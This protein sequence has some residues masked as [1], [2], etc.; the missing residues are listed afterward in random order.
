[1]L[2]PPDGRTLHIEAKA[3]GELPSIEQGQRILEI[4][5]SGGLAMWTPS[6]D[7][8]MQVLP[9]LLA[10]PARRIYYTSRTR[11]EICRPETFT[12]DVLRVWP[13]GKAKV[14]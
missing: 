14:R 3:T 13:R 7:V 6:L 11:A 1:V 4:N 10:D 9:V 5:A 12:G 2:P 8:V